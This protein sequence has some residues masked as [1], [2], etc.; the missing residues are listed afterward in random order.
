MARYIAGFVAA[1]V[2]FSCLDAAWLTLTAARIY[3][4][5]LGAIMIEKFRLAPAIAFYVVYLVGV[6]FFCHRTWC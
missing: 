5:V 3:R 6:T 1:A 4:P 2:V